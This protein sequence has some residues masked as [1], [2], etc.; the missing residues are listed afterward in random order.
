MSEREDELVANAVDYLIERGYPE[1]CTSNKKRIIRRK[2]ATLVLRDGEVF[3]KKFCWRKGSELL[4]P[5]HIYIHY[6]NIIYIYI[7]IYN[8]CI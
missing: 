4:L 5:N 3:Y 1:G 7:Y 2:A 8:I 6:C